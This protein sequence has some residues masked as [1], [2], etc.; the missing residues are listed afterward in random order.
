MINF[1][2]DDCRLLH[3]FFEHNQNYSSVTIKTY[4]KTKLLEFP[5]KI[6]VQFQFRN[7]P[8]HSP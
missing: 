3:I 2:E 5:T 8:F 1:N 6:R 4:T 7:C